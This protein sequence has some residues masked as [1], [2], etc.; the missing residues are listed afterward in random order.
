MTK[1]FFFLH[2]VAFTADP[3][4]RKFLASKNIP[5][6]VDASVNAIKRD[7]REGADVNERNTEGKT[8]LHCAVEGNNIPA[9]VALIK[10]GADVNVPDK[11]GKP[12]CIAR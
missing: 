10:H 8:P 6:D 11:N 5:K 2:L 7:I 1:K 4:I 3:E 12:H 9:L